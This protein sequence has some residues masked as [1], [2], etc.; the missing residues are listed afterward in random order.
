MIARRV[1]KHR[2]ATELVRWLRGTATGEQLANRVAALCTIHRVEPQGAG[3]EPLVRPL[4]RAIADAIIAGVAAPQRTLPI[5]G[6]HGHH[7]LP[8]LTAEGTRVHR[9]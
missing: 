4:D 8:G 6:F 9:Q 3:D 1:A 7:T 5:N 2:A